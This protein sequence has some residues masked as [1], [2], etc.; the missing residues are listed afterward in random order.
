[1]SEETSPR[2]S[3]RAARPFSFPPLRS[4][5]PC[6]NLRPI[7]GA[8]YDVD[9]ALLPERNK[10]HSYSAKGG[11]GPAQ[12]GQQVRSKETF[13]AGFTQ[14]LGNM[15][16]FARA[17]AGVSEW[18]MAELGAP[19]SVNAYRAPQTGVSLCPHNDPQDVLIL[20]LEGCR[21]WTVWGCSLFL[22]LQAHHHVHDRL[23][24][25]E[26]EQKEEPEADQEA[27]GDRP[28]RR[29]GHGGVLRSV[30][31][32]YELREGSLLYIP[33]GLLHRPESAATAVAPLDLDGRPPRPSRPS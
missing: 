27:E 3:G 10:A 14:V 28:R 11:A 16:P 26:E 32:T 31:T 30:H 21:R 2:R 20:Q 24:A 19:F 15:M 33:R 13:E 22:Y 9:A 1:M 5:S 17:A 18:L 4:A 25:E 8:W 12:A 6:Q 7:G 29:H 23:R